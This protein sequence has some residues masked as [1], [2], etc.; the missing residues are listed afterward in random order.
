MHP[1]KHRAAPASAGLSVWKPGQRN[2]TAMRRS[3]RWWPGRMSKR[4]ALDRRRQRHERLDP[5]DPRPC[6]RSG[7]AEHAGE[8]LPGVAPRAALRQVQHNAPHRAVDPDGDLQQPL[9]QGRPYCRPSIVQGA[10]SRSQG[11]LH[12][13]HLLGGHGPCGGSRSRAHLPERRDH[14]RG[15]GRVPTPARGRSA[16]NRCR[17][18]VSA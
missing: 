2:S 14:Q 12:A 16:A 6:R 5:A 3:R 13:Q 15:A 18:T 4:A 8:V 1:S 7:R 17:C 10:G 11:S 9:A